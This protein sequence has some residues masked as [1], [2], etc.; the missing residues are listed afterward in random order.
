MQERKNGDLR[1]TIQRTPFSNRYLSL[2]KDF[3]LERRKHKGPERDKRISRR[4]AIP[5]KN[6]HHHVPVQRRI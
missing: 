1:K 5:S 2:N 3:N 4:L 6:P